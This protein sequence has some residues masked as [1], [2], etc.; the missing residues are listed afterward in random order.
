MSY[1]FSFLIAYSTCHFSKGMHK[2]MMQLMIKK[3]QDGSTFMVM[4][5]DSQSRNLS[6][7]PALV[8][9][10]SYSLCKALVFFFVLY[11]NCLFW[12]LPVNAVFIFFVNVQH[13]IHFHACTCWCVLPIQPRSF[14]H[15]IG[16]HI[17]THIWNCWIHCNFFLL[18]T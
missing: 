15:C 10:P 12:L 9:A 2:M 11:S 13:R 6:L 5:S 18:S 16:G 4:F 3:K 7:L 1:P 17:C 8:L 14:I